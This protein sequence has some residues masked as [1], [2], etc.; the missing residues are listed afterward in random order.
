MGKTQPAVPVMLGAP[1]L[2]PAQ[3]QTEAHAPPQF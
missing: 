3:V 2:V 1:T